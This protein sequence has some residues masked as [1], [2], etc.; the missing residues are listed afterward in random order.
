[1]LDDGI[2]EFYNAIGIENVETDLVVLLISKY[3][4][5]KFFYH[6]LV[7]YEKHVTR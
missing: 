1:M 3:M 4:G 7:H 5:A 2:T 6:Y